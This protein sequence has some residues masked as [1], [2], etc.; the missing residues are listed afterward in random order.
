MGIVDPSRVPPGM[1]QMN[2]LTPPGVRMPNSSQSALSQMAN[3]NSSS[4]QQSQSN[5]GPPSNM[6]MRGQPPPQ[7]QM[8]P[9][10]GPNSLS[11]MPMNMQ[12]NQVRWPGPQQSG[13]PTQV[14]NY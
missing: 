9:Q 8:G 4:Q 11:P 7:T 6:V 10:M 14:L 5:Q 3:Y 13:G 1:N 12:Q 2:R